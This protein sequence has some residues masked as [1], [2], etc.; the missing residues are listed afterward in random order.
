[1]PG[2]HAPSSPVSFI[3][4]L[5]RSAAFALAILGLIVLIA[6]VAVNSRDQDPQASGSPTPTASATATSTGGTPAPDATATVSGSPSPSVLPR[7]KVTVVVLNGNRTAGLAGRVSEQLEEDGYKTGEPGNAETE[8]KT[9]IYFKPG[10][11]AEAEILRRRHFEWMSTDQLKRAT[12]GLP[13]AMLVVVLGTDH[14][15]P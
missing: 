7:S 11:K 14:Q 10:R 8:A 1:V 12:E 3:A 13:D 15:D 6:V 4:S 5:T 2:K 9:I